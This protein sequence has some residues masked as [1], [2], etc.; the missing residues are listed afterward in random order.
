[1]K[2]FFVSSV[3]FT[4]IL[5]VI[6]CKKQPPVAAFSMDKSTFKM[7]ESI[8]FTNESKNAD[9]Y[10]W[11]FGDGKK[12]TTVSPVH[13]FSNAGDVTIKLRATGSEGVDSTSQTITVMP[14]LTGIWRQTLSLGGGIFG[15]NGTMNVVQHEDNTLT[16]SYVYEDG[17]GTFTLK[18]T[19]KITGNSVYIEW[20]ELSYKF[21]GTVGPTGRTMGGDMLYEGASQGTWSAI[22]L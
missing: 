2:K 1:M 16:G 15:V 7:D 19:S 18:N 14:N 3:L 22:K 5:L 4:C 6:G 20:L 12:S 13:S 10:L 21:Q 17:Q 8:K 9:E 11:N